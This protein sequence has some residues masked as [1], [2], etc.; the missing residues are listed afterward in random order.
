MRLLASCGRARHGQHHDAF[1]GRST[2][3]PVS[4]V[5]AGRRGHKVTGFDPALI[6]ITLMA[7]KSS[8]GPAFWNNWVSLDKVEEGKHSESKL[9]DVLVATGL[10]L[11]L[12][13]AGGET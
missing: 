4:N 12:Q 10:Q 6:L 2:G 1:D 5:L 3:Q 9:K 8:L 7:K 13:P 11:E